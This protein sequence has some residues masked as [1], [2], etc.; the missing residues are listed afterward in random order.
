M[1][2]P[3]PDV[4][5]ILQRLCGSFVEYHTAH[6]LLSGRLLPFSS[7]K[8]EQGGFNPITVAQHLSNQESAAFSSCTGAA[9]LL[10][11]VFTDNNVMM[12]DTNKQHQQHKQQPDNS[13][14]QTLASLLLR[15]GS[16]RILEHISGQLVQGNRP[17]VEVLKDVWN[18]SQ[19]WTTHILPILQ[20][21]H[22]PVNRTT[23]R[24]YLFLLR[25]SSQLIPWTTH[26]AIQQVQDR[27]VALPES[28]RKQY[29]LK[30]EEEQNRSQ[31]L[32]GANHAFVLLQYPTAMTIDDSKDN[33][34]TAETTTESTT[35]HLVLQSWAYTYQLRDW[36]NLA[37]PSLRSSSTYTP[38]TSDMMHTGSRASSVMSACHPNKEDRE[39]TFKDLKKA[40]TYRR[41]VL[42][43]DKN[44]SQLLLLLETV[45]TAQS[46]TSNVESAYQQL[47]GVKLCK[48][49][50]S[51]LKEK[52]SDM[53]AM[54]FFCETS[55]TMN[56]VEK[57]LHTLEQEL[58]NSGS[59]ISPLK[60]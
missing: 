14:K 7:N 38:A 53:P 9:Y 26:D 60:F 46:W 15:A 51:S 23:P 54:T 47:F 8:P 59:T 13:I 48:P 42:A 52:Q 24:A 57:N 3:A 5:A 55:W 56:S 25:D 30:D 43:N 27:H 37:V 18:M 16:Q 4:I 19:S 35:E 6:R 36:L 1:R 58:R 33:K 34:T 39:K 28:V 20:T 41:P 11:D 22:K 45:C 44:W 2:Q 17:P 32:C 21:N 40:N 50:N 29:P 49:S 12:T 31:G 10:F